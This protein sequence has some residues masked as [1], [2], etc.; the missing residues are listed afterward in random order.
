MRAV[1]VA[2]LL[3]CAARIQAEEVNSFETG[4]ALYEEMSSSNPS[5]PER[6][7]A[8][9]YVAGIMDFL[10][11]NAMRDTSMRTCLT[12]GLTVGQ[13]FEVTKR[14]LEDNPEKRHHNAAGLVTIALLR[15]FPCPRE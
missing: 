7:Y 14:Y 5:G 4:N 8:M 6:V 9:G 15:A 12:T 1:L 10:S 11:S 13:V 2:L 3:L